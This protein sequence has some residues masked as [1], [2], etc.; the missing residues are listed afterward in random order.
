MKKDP[1]FAKIC[2]FLLLIFICP[3][4]GQRNGN[5]M[6]HGAIRDKAGNL[7]FATTGADA[8]IYRY[9]SAIDKFNNF[10]ISEGLC[11]NNVGSIME[12][13]AGKLWI[14][15]ERGVCLYDGKSFTEFGMTEG[16]CNT[17]INVLLEDRNGNFWFGTNGYGVCRYNPAT[18]TVTQFTKEQG[19]GSNFV[20]CML[21]DKAGNLWVGERAGGVSRFDSSTGNFNKI[22]CEGCLSNQIMGIIEDKGGSIW[23]VNLYNGLCRFDGKSFTHVTKENGLCNDTITCIYEDQ[24]GNLWLGSDAGN[25]VT[26]SAGL[27]RYNPSSGVSNHFTEKDGITKPN[28]WTIVEDNES[29]IWVGTKG[30]LYR[31]HSVSGRFIDYTFKLNSRTH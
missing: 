2:C 16:M 9:D 14:N 18:G 20:Q 15:T 31:Y 12:D 8:G 7:W 13:R 1:R 26:A 23:F 5:I 21:E 19:L 28:I 4:Y 29:N 3:S 30:G 22:T 10:T 27:C 17:D 6:F 11:D 24:K 25:S